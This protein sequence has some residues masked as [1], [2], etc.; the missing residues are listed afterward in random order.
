MSKRG[1][2]G[3]KKKRIVRFAY[4]GLKQRGGEK[5]NAEKLRPWINPDEHRF[6]CA[7]RLQS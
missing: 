3:K 5:E 7:L 2:E 4:N 1:E 6:D